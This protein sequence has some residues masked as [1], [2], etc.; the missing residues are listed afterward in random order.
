MEFQWPLRNDPPAL[1][2]DE[3]HVWA[4][5][6]DGGE[7][8]AEGYAAILSAAELKRAEALVTGGLRR[9]FVAAHGALRKLLGLYLDERP[10]I[11]EF[12]YDRG[13]KPRLGDKYAAANL[14]FNLSH[15][16]SLA[17]VAIVSGC[18]VGI[19]V[20]QVREVHELERIARRHFHPVEVEEVM[21]AYEDRHRAFFRC[22]TAKE[23]VLKAL[24]IGIAE[25]LNC[26]RVPSVGDVDGW[27]DLSS[28]PKTA[29]SSQCRL[30]RLAPCDGYEAAVAFLGS[31]PRIQCYLFEA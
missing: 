5:P 25:S 9:R 24:G 18:E 20:E 11:V 30:T 12:V 4:V 6:L 8:S 19:D 21:F 16:A 13:G 2:V 29:K 22:W 23:A 26:F 15:S 10:E 27:V 31:E 1:A 28:L 7:A 3:A 14:L 17:L